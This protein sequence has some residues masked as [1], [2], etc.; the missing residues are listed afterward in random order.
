MQG[1]LMGIDRK[2]MENHFEHI[3]NFADIGN[4]LDQPVKTYSSGMYVRLAFATAINA[5]PD[6]LIIDEALAVGDDMFRRRCF[7][8]IEEFKE[9]GKTILFVSHSLET[10]TSICDSALLLDRGEILE[11]GPPKTIVNIYSK[12]LSEREEEYLK[13]QY[14]N[15]HVG[16]RGNEEATE[17]KSATESEFRYGAGGAELLD[18]G[19]FNHKNE[20]VN[21]IEHGENFTIRVRALFNKK[22]KDPM[23]GFR[24]RTLTGVDIYGTNT[25][26]SNRPIGEIEAGSEV[27]IDFTQKMRL[28]QGS[29]ALT[30]GIA[31]DVSKQMIFHDR[32]MDV[33]IFRVVGNGPSAGLVDMD[34]SIN[35][36]VEPSIKID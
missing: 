28:N 6:I 22:M 21:I 15:N 31:E 12:L 29:Y 35:V 33:I 7:N 19:I 11:I 32:R 20:R 13:Q 5:N 36:T 30:S 8:K 1:A 2:E 14:N 25:I 34:T 26:L 23:I 10:V 9:D 4:F 24:I 27:S 17:P 16:T 18:I 3:V